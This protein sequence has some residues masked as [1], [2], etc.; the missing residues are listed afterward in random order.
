LISIK[1]EYESILEQYRD[2]ASQL[3]PAKELLFT[4]TNEYERR[5]ASHYIQE[6]E[7][8]ISL[9]ETIK[10]LESR[11]SRIKQEREESRIM[12]TKLQQKLKELSV[13]LLHESDARKLAIMDLNQL[14]T[15]YKDLLKY[16]KD[17][18]DSENDDAVILKIAL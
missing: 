3:E 9:K 2:T 18:N 13:E 7:E 12:L 1:N 5:I 4:V 17:L 15:E 8:T 16:S 6:K 10:Q 14:Q 11:I